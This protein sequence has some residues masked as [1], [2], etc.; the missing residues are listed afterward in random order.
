MVPDASPP[1]GMEG[2]WEQVAHVPRF[3]VSPSVFQAMADTATPQGILAVF[4]L[5]VV[6]L[7]EVLQK[8]AAPGRVP[9]LAVL[10]GIQDPGN[11]GTLVRTAVAAGVSAVLTGPNTVDLFSPRALRAAAGLTPACPILPP[12]ESQELADYFLRQG[13]RFVLLDVDGT[14]SIY[15]VDWRGPVGLIV[16]SE[17]QGASRVWR[18]MAAECV[19][20]PMQPPVESLNA[21]VSGAICLYEA[22]RQRMGSP[23][24]ACRSLSGCAIM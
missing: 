13:G 23:G 18:Q 8:M 7:A 10:D 12:R 14:R 1:E 19:R 22:L 9:L 2:L 4:H 11:G 24:E 20:I 15:D 3:T 17:G 16:G 5:P 21:A 6:T